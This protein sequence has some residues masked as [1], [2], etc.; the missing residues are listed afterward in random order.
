MSAEIKT[1]TL[2]LKGIEL[3]IFC[4]RFYDSINAFY[5]NPDNLKR[6]EKWQALRKGTDDL[7]STNPIMHGDEE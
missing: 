7:P 4:S 1:T 3:R 6:F 5:K 2:P